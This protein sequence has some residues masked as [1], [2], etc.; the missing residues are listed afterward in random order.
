MALQ[1]ASLVIFVALNFL[2]ERIELVS[3]SSMMLGRVQ[4]AA[5]VYRILLPLVAY[6][7]ILSFGLFAAG[8]LFADQS[9]RTL[10][11][12]FVLT[13]MI[14]LTMALFTN[15]Q[16]ISWEGRRHRMSASIESLQIVSDALQKNWPTSDMDHYLLGPIMAYPQWDP[17]TLILLTPK[18]V[19]G[20]FR[21]AAIDRSKKGIWRFELSSGYEKIWL[22]HRGD[23]KLDDEFT[24]GIDQKLIRQYYITLSP[25]WFLVRYQ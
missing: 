13:S 22:E 9:Q 5:T 23:S 12:L 1:F 3:L 4:S 6:S 21:I 25:S 15:W 16:R 19:D 7:L 24:N 8:M 10:R 11:N 17:S 18:P 14:G 2:D 20:R